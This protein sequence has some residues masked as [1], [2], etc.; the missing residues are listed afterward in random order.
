M[1]PANAEFCTDVAQKRNGVT[2]KI[3][4]RLAEV[5]GRRIKP[6]F[7]VAYVSTTLRRSAKCQLVLHHLAVRSDDQNVS[8]PDLQCYC[9][10][11]ELSLGQMMFGQMTLLAK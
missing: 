3:G 7:F 11:R 6:S 5:T 8:R 10:L 9:Q 1:A 2:E 4:S